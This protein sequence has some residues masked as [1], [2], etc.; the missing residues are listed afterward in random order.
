M[1]RCQDVMR[2]CGGG[3]FAMFPETMAFR[4]SIRRGMASLEEAIHDAALQGI[5]VKGCNQ[6]FGYDG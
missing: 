3:N 4:L 2:G 5:C 1:F 6:V